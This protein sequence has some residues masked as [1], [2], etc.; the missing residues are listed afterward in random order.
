METPQIFRTALLRQAYATVSAKGLVV[1]DEVSAMEAIGVA[2]KLVASPSP[3]LKIT[4]PADI[5]LATAL[6]R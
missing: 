2:T 4:V 5:E 3:N 1:T 6:L